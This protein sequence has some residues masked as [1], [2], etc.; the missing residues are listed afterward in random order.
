MILNPREGQF[1]R[2]SLDDVADLAQQE[3]DPVPSGVDGLAYQSRPAAVGGGDLA[4]SDRLFRSG[5]P[6]GRRAEFG[7]GQDSAA[8]KV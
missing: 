1:T 3:R 5:Q 8:A 7:A 6:R 2:A 4:G